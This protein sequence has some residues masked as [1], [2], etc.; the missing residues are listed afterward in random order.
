VVSVGGR[1][2]GALAPVLTVML[3]LR[4][5]NW[6]WSGWIYGVGGLLVAWLFWQVF[7][8]SPEQHPQCNDAERQVLAPAA[9]AHPSQAVAHREP[10]P[11]GA[12]LASRG[13]WLMCLYQ[14]FTNIGWVFL[15][16]WMP[17]YLRDTKHLS[18]EVSG[19]VTTLSLVLGIGGLLAGGVLTDLCT[20]RFGV[21]LGRLI[22][23]AGT[24]FVAAGGYLAALWC[25][26]PWALVA[27][28]GLVACATDTGLP[29]T[30]AYIQD[31][32]GRHV[33]P[34]FGWANMCGNFG[35]ALAPKLLPWVNAGWDRN[36][37][38][39]E[40]LLVC[41]GAF[42]LSGLMALGINAT[43]PVVAAPNPR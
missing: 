7:R 16:T 3:I 27:V 39:Q 37:D 36:G 38:W 25:D 19:L 35:A 21:R 40:A 42:A 6:R 4:F 26:S 18:D 2:G 32:G 33:A 17:R 30:W 34:I 43:R 20:R 8:E 9:G 13:L 15:V 31:V 28:F 23:L 24:R 5:E 22:P 11:F 41:A 10:F 29:A 14:F 12:M 1:L